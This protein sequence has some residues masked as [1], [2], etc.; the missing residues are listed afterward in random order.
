MTMT[1]ARPSVSTMKVYIRCTAKRKDGRLCGQLLGIITTTGA[2]N[3]VLEIQCSRCGEKA[4][5][6]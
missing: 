2:F 1:E 5:F 3:A 4:E 6:R